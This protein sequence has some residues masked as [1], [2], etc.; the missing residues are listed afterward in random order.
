M[1]TQIPNCPPLYHHFIPT[2]FV[3]CISKRGNWM[4]FNQNLLFTDNWLLSC[5]C[6]WLPVAKTVCK[7][8]MIRQIQLFPK[9]N[10]FVSLKAR[11]IFCNFVVIPINCHCMVLTIL[12]AEMWIYRDSTQLHFNTCIQTDVKQSTISI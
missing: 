11:F 2:G 3:L 8:K 4:F 9:D 6:C 1:L 10:L 7:G 5:C 12:F